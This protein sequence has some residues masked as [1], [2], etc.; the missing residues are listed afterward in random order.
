MAFVVE[1]EKERESACDI[2]Q[3][4][5]CF[6]L[7][8]WVE[9]LYHCFWT[10]SSFIGLNGCIILPHRTHK[11]SQRCF[12]SYILTPTNAK[13]RFSRFYYAFATYNNNRAKIPMNTHKTT[14]IKGD[15]AAE[16]FLMEKVC[17]LPLLS[18]QNQKRIQNINESKVH[19]ILALHFCFQIF[20]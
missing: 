3:I 2:D 8:S 18:C 12:H 13:K 10:E 15:I 9:S 20:Y 4:R 16:P 19:V 11:W 5:C 6:C 7:Y 17:C 1:L 14:N